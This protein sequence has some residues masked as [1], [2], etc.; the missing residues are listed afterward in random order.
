MA[1]SPTPS[2]AVKAKSS[3]RTPIKGSSKKKPRARLLE[4]SA[5]KRGSEDAFDETHV[6][7]SGDFKQ[8]KCTPIKGTNKVVV[9]KNI[10]G[11]PLKQKLEAEV[12]D[13][14]LEELNHFDML[15]EITGGGGEDDEELIEHE[16]KKWQCPKCKAMN[17]NDESICKTVESD[18]NNICGGTPAVVKLLTRA[19]CFDSEVSSSICTYRSFDCLC[20]IIVHTHALHFYTEHRRRRGIADHAPRQIP[21]KAKYACAAMLPRTTLEL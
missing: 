6:I 8:F 4:R 18:D 9:H 16:K 13:D 21:K 10:R 5:S 19:G 2:Q 20:Y 15:C 11:T 14:G 7:V 3:V 1:E 12:P 17:F